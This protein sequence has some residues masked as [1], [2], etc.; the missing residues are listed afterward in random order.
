MLDRSRFPAWCWPRFLDGSDV[1][2]PAPGP[3]LAVA[4]RF[5][6]PRC[7]PKK[8]A[9]SASPHI[10]NVGRGILPAPVRC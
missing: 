6:D 8:Y 1:Y 3:A 9:R 5:P 2:G 10:A 4:P 7:A